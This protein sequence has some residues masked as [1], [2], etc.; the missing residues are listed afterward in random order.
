MYVYGPR[1]KKKK[2]R[3]KDEVRSFEMRENMVQE[4]H[5]YIGGSAISC[6]IMYMYIYLYIH[7]ISYNIMYMLYICCIHV[8][9]M[10]YIYICIY[11]VYFSCNFFLSP[12]ISFLF[13]SLS[14]F[15]SLSSKG[16]RRRRSLRAPKGAFSHDDINRKFSFI[17]FKA[18]GSKHFSAASFTKLTKKKKKN[19]TDG[20][21]FE[22][23]FF[24]PT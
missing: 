19:R 16:D 20:I 7:I 21:R 4:K 3:E 10:L 23:A 1:A 6:N 13:V 9:K 15:F 5:K 24:Y 8:M 12:R 22:T 14:F 11:I 17:V 18:V 2:K